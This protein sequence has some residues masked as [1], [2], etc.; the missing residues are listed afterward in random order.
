MEQRREAA[1]QEA[2]VA[3]MGVLLGVI[4]GAFITLGVIIYFFGEDQSG[5]MTA[6]NNSPAQTERMIRNKNAPATFGQG[7]SQ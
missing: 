1:F 6:A 2:D 7:N 3:G 4:A 5:T